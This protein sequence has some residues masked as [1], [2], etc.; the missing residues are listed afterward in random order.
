MRDQLE[1]STPPVLLDK[2]IVDR[3]LS[4]LALLTA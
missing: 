2:D 1:A 3:W 4:G